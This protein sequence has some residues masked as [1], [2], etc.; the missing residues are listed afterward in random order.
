MVREEEFRKDKD[1]AWAY[2]DGDRS[3]SVRYSDQR[4]WAK[5]DTPI[6]IPGQYSECRACGGKQVIVIY[7]KSG[8]TADGTVVEEEL[9]CKDCGKYTQYRFDDRV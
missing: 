2:E 1:W 8:G 6:D 7:Q 5:D 4:K 3:T 9:L